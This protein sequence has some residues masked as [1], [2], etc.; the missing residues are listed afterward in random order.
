[1]VASDR[2][3][4]SAGQPGMTLPVVPHATDLASALSAITQLKQVVAMLS[5]Q[6]SPV[7]NIVG[8]GPLNNPT[9]GFNFGGLGVIGGLSS[10]LSLRGGAGA[11]VGV[12]ADA[13]AW[14]RGAGKEGDPGRANWQEIQRVTQRV[15]IHNPED[16]EQWVEIERIMKL[17]LKHNVTEELLVWEYKKRI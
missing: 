12:E 16:E 7:N 17:V 5:G 4:P 9:P 15:R 14:G 2:P 6:L 11:P 3:T 8:T 13:G 1:M 10:N